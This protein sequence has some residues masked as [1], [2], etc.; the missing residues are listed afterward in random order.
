M[1]KIQVLDCTLRDGGYCND[2]HFG[3]ENQKKIIRG[4]VD[5]GIDIIECGFFMNS[6]LYDSSRTRFSSV[7]QFKAVIPKERGNQLYVA[8]TDYGKFNPDELPEYD[9]T[10][11]DGLRIAFHKKDRYKALETCLN[12]KKKG[13]RVFV[14]PMVSINYTDEEFIE[15][16]HMANKFNP[17]AF[18]IV[19]SF[20]S[21]LQ[22]DLTRM[23]YMI[24]HN[25][26]SSI[27]IGF[28]SHNNMQLAYSNAQAL[29]HIP[30]QRDLIIDSSVHGMGRGAGNLNT[31][32]F[33]GYLNDNFNKKYGLK[34]LLIVIDEIIS[35]FY[36]KEPWGYSLPN[37]LSA[38]HNTHPNY[39][40]YLDNKKTLTVE[41]M[42]EIFTSMED[43]K[44]YN[45]DRHY[46]EKLYLEYMTSGLSDEKKKNEL[47]MLLSGK[48]LLLIAPGKSSW[49]E[50]EKIISFAQEK[51]VVSISIN[52]AYDEYRTDYI[53]LS[54]LRRFRKLSEEDYERSIITSNILE[55]A[56][57][58][59]INY[60][61]LL[62]EV[63]AVKDNAGL[64]A[65]KFL[66]NC[67][68]KDIYLAGMDGYAYDFNQN[69]G[70]SNMTIVAK[71]DILDAMNSGMMNVLKEFQKKAN[72]SFLTKPRNIYI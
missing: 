40:G 42:N 17:Y 24:E 1:Q 16:I 33:V 45:Y 6:I 29:V 30:S 38:M 72:I 70:D 27:K 66:I 67:G 32:I 64:M 48:K 37:Y 11:I 12:V 54:N 15:L 4:L 65:I 7:E 62:S 26:K 68:V 60:K 20:G 23:F 14:Q 55:D 59:K 10:S 47:E 25:L 35:G 50:K 63:E 21:M 41:A 8:L 51:D 5:S 49:E 43:E 53:F 71:K 52:F 28:H 56:A 3:F 69:Y 18:Y 19:D 46:I 36:Q 57:Y 2:C 31:E 44:R 9:G 39:A 61:E 58:L 13:Y 34:P 22:K